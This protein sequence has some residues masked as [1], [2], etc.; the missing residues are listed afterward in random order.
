MIKSYSVEVLHLNRSTGLFR[1]VCNYRF[2]S[3]VATA[4]SLKDIV[5]RDVKQMGYDPDCILVKDVSTGNS[6]IINCRKA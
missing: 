6:C 5:R 4:N 3:C 2:S 1:I